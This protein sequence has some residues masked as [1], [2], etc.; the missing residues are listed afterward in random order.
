MG[1]GTGD[2]PR[3]EV[4]SRG[5]GRPLAGAGGRCASRAPSP[6]ASLPP[7]VEC[8]RYSDSSGGTRTRR[9]EQGWEPRR[10]RGTPGRCLGLRGLRGCSR[11]SGRCSCSGGAGRGPRRAGV[12]LR[13][14]VCQWK[15]PAGRGGGGV[16]LRI[17]LRRERAPGRRG[18]TD[19]RPAS[20]LTPAAL[21]PLWAAG[22]AEAKARRREAGV[23]VSARTRLLADTHT[24]HATDTRHAPSPPG[25]A[26][27]RTRA[28]THTHP[29]APQQP[30]VEAA[31]GLDPGWGWRVSEFL[32]IRAPTAGGDG[33]KVGAGAETGGYLFRRWGW[34]L[35]GDTA[36]GE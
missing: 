36:G 3:V 25:A 15:D 23:A 1:S 6:A 29:Q 21:G 32:R 33:E 11:L 14:C 10:G 30:L 7:A 28:H 27:T 24:G 8:S 18:R 31:L 4:E 16:S 22:P 2:G 9:G 34:G 19:R 26:H 20:A 35:E 5:R 13:V 17:G 12:C